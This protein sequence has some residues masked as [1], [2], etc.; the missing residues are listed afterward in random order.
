MNTTHPE[1]TDVVAR[2][3]TGDVLPPLVG[4]SVMTVDAVDDTALCVRQLLWRACLTPDEFATAVTILH[5]AGAVTGLELAELLRRHYAGG[6]QVTT[7]CS[8][9]PNLCAVVL[10]DLGL[11]PRG[12]P[13]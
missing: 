12:S 7:D 8:R 3:R 10:A 2:Y 4:S 5:E 11:V 6:P 9:V 13:A 1:W